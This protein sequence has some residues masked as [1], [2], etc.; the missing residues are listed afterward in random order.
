LN[1]CLIE[2]S[3][4]HVH[5]TKEVRDA[6]FGAGYTLT[7]IKDL[8]QPGEYACDEQ[9]TV[10][11][12]KGSCKARV[13]GP[14]R[15]KTQVELSLSDAQALGI[16]APLRESGYIDGTPGCTLT[17]LMGAEG[18]VELAQGCIIAQRHVHMKP[19]DAEE[20]GVV[21]KQLVQ[22][23]NSNGYVYDNVLVRVKDYF[24]LRVHIDVDEAVAGGIGRGECPQGEIIA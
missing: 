17:G 20:L 13:V 4:R 15:S 14:E 9:V 22:V 19:E 7:P 18:T 6:L 1:T 16:D 24:N 5:I 8:S 23:K 10:T 11:G 21:D 3:A 12:P 2:T